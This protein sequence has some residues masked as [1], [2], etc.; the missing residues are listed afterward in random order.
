METGKL[1]ATEPASPSST[2]H[3][4]TIVR[5]VS[6][7]ALLRIFSVASHTHNADI[8]C[9]VWYSD[10]KEAVPLKAAV[11]AIGRGANVNGTEYMEYLYTCKLPT[12]LITPSE[13][14]IAFESCGQATVL[15]PV[16]FANDTGVVHEF[17]VCVPVTYWHVSPFRII[18]WMELNKLYGVTQV[19]IYNSSLFNPGLSVFLKYRD[20]GDLIM[21]QGSPPVDAS[22]L[23]AIKL[24]VLA[25]LN[26]CMYRNMYQYRYLIAIDLD[27]VIIPRSAKNY[28]EMIAQIHRDTHAQGSWPA[29]MFHNAYFWTD[30]Q[31]KR[32]KPHF[33]TILRYLTR[34]KVSPLNY[35]AKSIIDPRTCVVLTNH[36]CSQ[37]VSTVGHYWTVGV[38][39]SIATCQHY[40]KCHLGH[41]QCEKSMRTAILDESA[42]THRDALSD[43]MYQTLASMDIG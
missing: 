18:E 43:N 10:F 26:D 24:A 15:L 8:Y 27:E 13:V 21:Q 6:D 40:K 37:R 39:Q 33:S 4:T 2:M 12:S 25:G 29:Y 5:P 31:P 16:V 32:P 36:F 35:A 7:S 17:G 41:S 28:T 30:F 14:S 20:Q 23:W 3:I 11:S 22:G 1:P 19:N 38:N 34:T 9:Q 42:E